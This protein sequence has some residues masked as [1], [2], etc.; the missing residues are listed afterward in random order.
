MENLQETIATEV[1]QAITETSIAKN[2]TSLQKTAIK[3]I[4][5]TAAPLKRQLLRNQEKQAAANQAF[6]EKNTQLIN[7]IN[8][9]EVAIKEYSNGFT[10]AQ[11]FPELGEV[12]EGVALDI[13]ITLRE[14]AEP[15]AENAHIAIDYTQEEP[16]SESVQNEGIEGQ[17]SE[18]L[19]C[20]PQAL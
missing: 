4:Y 3:A 13:P 5:R 2:L 20:K 12:P 18:G 19:N 7:A 14:A 15:I 1:A 9:I 17:I 8:S 16:S 10:Y 6:D 11:I